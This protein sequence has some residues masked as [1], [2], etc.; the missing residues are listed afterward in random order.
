V[1]AANSLF[2]F[3]MLG[4]GLRILNIHERYIQAGRIAEE[5][6]KQ[7]FVCLETERMKFSS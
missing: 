4:F 6:F 1:I 2:N 5:R 3:V 7:G